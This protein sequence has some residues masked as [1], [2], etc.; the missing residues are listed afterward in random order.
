MPAGGMTAD[1]RQL[2][3]AVAKLLREQCKASPHGEVPTSASYDELDGL[4]TAVEDAR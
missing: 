2:L 3:L 1:E 4:I